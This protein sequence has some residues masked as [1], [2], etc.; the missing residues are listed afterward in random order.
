MAN[1]R[2]D[3]LLGVLLAIKNYIKTPQQYALFED[4]QRLAHT[5]LPAE[6]RKILEIVKPVVTRWNS[7][8]SCFERAVTLQ[9]VVNGYANCYIQRVETEDL[10]A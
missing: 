4:L 2:I 8:C 5:E 6:Q 7:Y 10:Y 1:W 3:R 9:L